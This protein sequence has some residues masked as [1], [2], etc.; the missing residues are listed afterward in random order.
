M[1]A[2]L[3]TKEELL[4]TERPAVSTY[5]GGFT[6]SLGSDCTESIDEQA[7]IHPTIH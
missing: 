6:S 2:E 1:S 4:G 3:G 5:F 7:T